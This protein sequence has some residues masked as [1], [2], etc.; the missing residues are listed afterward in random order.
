MNG[1]WWVPQPDND[2]NSSFQKVGEREGVGAVVPVFN[3]VEM[4]PVF[5]NRMESLDRS[6]NLVFID[7]G[8]TDG[9]LELLSASA[10]I[11]LIGHGRNLGY[12]QSLIETG[13]ENRL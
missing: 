1:K 10:R 3:E 6:L 2:N 4:L 8:S 12:G 5:F 7:N 9:T 13:Q 11:T